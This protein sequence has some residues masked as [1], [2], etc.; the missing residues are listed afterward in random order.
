MTYFYRPRVTGSYTVSQATAQVIVQNCECFSVN[1][2]L[3]LKGVYA[4]FP[5]E[6]D[7]KQLDLTEVTFNTPHTSTEN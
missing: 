1:K 2:M 4:S 7:P 6:Q 5:P 3:C